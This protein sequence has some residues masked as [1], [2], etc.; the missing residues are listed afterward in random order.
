MQRYRIKSRYDNKLNVALAEETFGIASMLKE[1]SPK[2]LLKQY[3]G[4]VKQLQHVNSLKAQMKALQNTKEVIEPVLGKQL[5]IYEVIHRIAS[6]KF[7]ENPNIK[8]RVTMSQAVGIHPV[9]YRRCNA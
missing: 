3:T 1:N 9:Y 8:P 5:P 2:L 7:I 4:A 6:G